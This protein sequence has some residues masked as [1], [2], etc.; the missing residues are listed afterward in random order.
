MDQE[1]P[2]HG[3]EEDRDQPCEGGGENG[4]HR[5][6]RQDPVELLG[7]EAGRPVIVQ[8][9]G[10]L[11]GRGICSFHFAGHSVAALASA[12]RCIGSFESVAIYPQ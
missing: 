9:G 5:R 12:A 8:N 11:A 4:G 2:E 7:A 10:Q 3:L 6:M 1:R